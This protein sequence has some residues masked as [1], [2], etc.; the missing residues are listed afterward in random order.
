MATFDALESSEQDSR[1]VE[2]YQIS[3]GT[4]TFRYTSGS[5]TITIGA[6]DYIPL[7]IARSKIEQGSDQQNRTLTMT[8]PS[9]NEFAQRYINVPPGQTATV[10][11]YRYQRDEAPAFATQ[12]LQFKGQVQTC[13]FPNDGFSAE[14]ALRSIE[15]ALNKNIPRFSFMGMCNHVLYDSN[16][17]ANPAS[18][19]L[20]GAVTAISGNTI[21]VAGVGASPLDFTGGYV[22]SGN[23]FRMILS[24]S[25]DVL[26]ML[27]PFEIDPTS[28]TVFAGCDH[29]VA[30]DCALVFDRVADF[31]GFPFVPNRN[32][33]ES[34][35]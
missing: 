27:L 10:N 2:L 13:R 12:I 16:C 19:N 22:Q 18:F 31:G 20:A 3:I 26:T 7:A 11:I 23:D 21:T 24:T 1:P 30:G 34:G 25:G 32:I 5:N 29:L 35:L 9:S 33:F 8:M 17:G 15:T 6:D 4:D 28:V 14:F